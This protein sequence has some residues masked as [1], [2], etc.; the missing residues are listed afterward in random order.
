LHFVD[1]RPFAAKFD[2]EALQFHNAG[3]SAF[4]RRQAIGWLIVGRQR[5]LAFRIQCHKHDV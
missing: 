4:L 2:E 1:D 3:T 5:K